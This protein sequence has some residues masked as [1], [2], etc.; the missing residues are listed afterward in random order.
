[1][2]KKNI[3]EEEPLIKKHH[4]DIKIIVFAIIAIILCAIFYILALTPTNKKTVQISNNKNSNQAQNN[5]TNINNA[6]DILADQSK[7]KKIK[8]YDELKDFLLSKETHYQGG[9]M[10]M[11]KSMMLRAP[12]GMGGEMLDSAMATEADSNDY[13]ETNIQVEGVDEADIIKTD[14]K[15]IYAVSENELFI[16]NAFPA[17]QSKIISKIKFQ[18]KPQNIYINGNS[19]AVYGRDDLIYKTDLY[20][21]LRPNSNFTFFKVF[22]LSDKKNPK[23]I[24]D[25]DFEGTFY[26]S[27]MVGDYVYFITQQPARY[28]KN[29]PEPIIL[30]NGEAIL[31]EK[32][33]DIYYINMPYSSYNFTHIA[34][35]NIKNNR[36]IINSESYLLSYGQNLYVSQKNIYITYTKYIREETL[37]ADSVKEVIFPMLDSDSRQTIQE[38][39]AT[40]ER[41]LSYE[42]KANKILNIVGMYVSLLSQ[43]EQNAIEKKV[44]QK[45]TEKYEDISKELEKTV[46][47]KIGINKNKLEYKAVGEVTGQV[48]NQFSMDENNGYFRIATTK[49]RT[50][51]RLMDEGGSESYNNLYVLDKDL[52]IVGKIE[53]LAKGERIYSARF[54]QNRAYLVTF[55]QID[56]LFVIDLK[57][58]TNPRVL[59]KLKIPGFSNYLHPYDETTLIGLGKDSGNWN[60]RLKLSLFDVSNVGDPKEIDTYI[61]ENKRGNS[62][63]LNDHKAFLFSKEKNLLVIPINLGDSRILTDGII[64]EKI[65][66]PNPSS[67]EYFNGAAIFYI[68]EDGF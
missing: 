14:G 8:D 67:N 9:N 20:K 59:G 57:N 58:P 35:I 50:W 46:I 32:M 68:D 26:N 12:A 16:I 63:A 30:S 13:S 48:L 25:L 21:T 34:A 60:A 37:M 49:N 45:L 54:M 40:S 17:D 11:E 38:I 44:K 52:N 62:I 19:L 1:M 56:P 47:H 51:S 10:I 24:R 31:R 7:I 22:D 2:A 65:M 61:F 66:M 43:E 23:Q 33:M 27:R 29:M 15:Y 18:S 39:E 36:E 5:K 41:V 28:Y 42:E 4:L 64:E 3:I 6:A 55:K 53:D